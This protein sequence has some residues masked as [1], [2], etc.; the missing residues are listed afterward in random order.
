VIGSL[1]SLFSDGDAGVDLAKP[2][3]AAADAAEERTPSLACGMP[4]GPREQ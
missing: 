1:S 2:A 3:S 4:G